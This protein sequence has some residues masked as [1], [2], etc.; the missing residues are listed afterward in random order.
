MMSLASLSMRSPNNDSINSKRSFHRNSRLLAKNNNND[1]SVALRFVFK[2]KTI[3]NAF[4][5]GGHLH[6]QED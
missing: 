4:F 5:R 6:P 3:Q 1:V 2:K